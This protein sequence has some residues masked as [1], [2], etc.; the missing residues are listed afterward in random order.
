[1]RDDYADKRWLR[2]NGSQEI[3]VGV[4]LLVALIVAGILEWASR[5]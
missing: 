2:E 1:M 4:L 5:L 3:P